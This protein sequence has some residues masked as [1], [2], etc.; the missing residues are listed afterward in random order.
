MGAKANRP[1]SEIPVLSVQTLGSGSQPSITFAPDV[2]DQYFSVGAG[3][4]FSYQIALDPNSDIVN[5]YGETDA[6]FWLVLGQ[7]TG[8]FIGTAPMYSGFE[9]SYTINCKAANA[10]GGITNFTVNITVTPVTYT[11]SKSLSFDGD[12]NYLQGNPTNMASLERLSSG[13][14]N[15]WTVAMWIKPAM[16]VGVN[17]LLVFGSGEATSGGTISMSQVNGGD[18]ILS[19]GN[20]YNNIT[21]TA[22]DAF[23]ENSWAHVVVTF[24]G[25]TTGGNSAEVDNYYSRFKIY[26]NGM[27]IEHEGSDTNDGY[28]GDISGSYSSNDI[29]LIGRDNLSSN[30]FGGSINQVAIWGSDESAFVYTMYNSGVTQDLS[31]LSSPPAHYYEIEDSVTTITDL[32]GFANLTGYNFVNSDLITETP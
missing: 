22:G 27:L 10:I 21:L 9:D 2:Q 30:F 24:D 13:D 19:Y 26:L 4:A 15:A 23:Y 7:A 20:I 32:L 3:E 29:Y 12:T 28:S 18:F 16:N 5:M 1:Y 25:G 17:P 11:N 8:Q 14:G 31:F 6:P